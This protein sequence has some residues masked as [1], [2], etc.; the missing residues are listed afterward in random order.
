[1]P[2]LDFDE[3]ADQLERIGNS[4]DTMSTTYQHYPSD[5]FSD[6]K[7]KEVKWKKKEEFKY[8]D[9]EFEMKY[10]VEMEFESKKGYDYDDIQTLLYKNGLKG[11]RVTYDGSLS[12]NGFEIISKPMDSI[13]NVLDFLVRVT[14]V[15]KGNDYEIFEGH[16]CAIHIHISNIKNIINLFSLGTYYGDIFEHIK[17]SHDNHLV[18]RL[19]HWPLPEHINRVKKQDKNDVIRDYP[20][21]HIQGLIKNK[22]DPLVV[23][24][25]QNICDFF[26]G[27]RRCTIRYSGWD[28]PNRTMEFRVFPHKFDNELYKIYVKI[29]G[30]LIHYA[31]RHE[32]GELYDKLYNDHK[33]LYE[34]FESFNEIIGLNKKQINKLYNEVLIV[35]TIDGP[36]I[37]RHISMDDTQLPH[38]IRLCA[39]RVCAERNVGEY[40]YIPYGN[41]SYV[42]L[43]LLEGVQVFEVQGNGEVSGMNSSRLYSLMEAHD[44]FYVP[45]TIID[46]VDGNLVYLVNFNLPIH[47]GSRTVIRGAG[48]RPHC[49]IRSFL[50]QNDQFP[51]QG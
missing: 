1:M 25:S 6:I 19:S 27:S 20:I 36:D 3:L 46:R 51:L 43:K 41:N 42:L 30:N 28:S 14:D 8:P 2:N 33:P 38:Y 5:P 35:K 23:Y 22:L 4:L 16:T 39:N 17:Q 12:E 47:V 26:M 11:V 31:N 45:W 7:V 50:V 48:T 13:I 15:L 18:H 34:K 32:E 10:G 49:V 29:V 40:L 44:N 9:E 37:E 24:K 21:S